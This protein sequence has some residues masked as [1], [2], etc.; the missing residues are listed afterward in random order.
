MDIKKNIKKR[1][2]EKKKK[3]N[4]KNDLWINWLLVLNKL[5]GSI[6]KYYLINI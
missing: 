6:G 2:I 5:N 4:L 3:L 1:K